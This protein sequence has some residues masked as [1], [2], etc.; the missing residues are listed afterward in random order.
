MAEVLPITEES[1]HF[2]LHNRVGLY[3]GY[4]KAETKKLIL[5]ESVIDAVSLLQQKEIAEAIQRTSTLWH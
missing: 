3:P 4:P 2:Y 1:K 5:T